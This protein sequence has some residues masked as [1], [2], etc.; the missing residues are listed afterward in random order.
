MINIVVISGF[1]GSGKSTF[2]RYLL[3]QPE[4]KG[5]QVIINEF[6]PISVDH[7]LVHFAAERTH[8][9]AGGCL[10][11]AYRQDLPQILYPLLDT[12]RAN[13]SR[14][15]AC[16]PD[17]IL[18]TTGL[19]D[20]VAIRH[21]LTADPVLRHQVRITKML[22]TIDAAHFL[23]NLSQYPEVTA[24]C[25][26]ADTFLITK[27]D[28]VSEEAIAQIIA[29]LT[30][31][32]PTASIAFLDHGVP[33]TDVTALLASTNTGVESSTAA[34]L[35]ELPVTRHTESVRSATY[36][37]PDDLDLDFFV[38]WFSLLIHR[39]GDKL[40]RVKGILAPPN[41]TSP[42]LFQALQHVIHEPEHIHLA[43]A[44]PTNTL[45]L[46]TKDILPET[47]SHSLTTLRDILDPKVPSATPLETDIVSRIAQQ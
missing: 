19:A 21:T 2:L 4:F 16:A 44:T 46:I 37:L 27:R 22:V 20:P 23:S 35:P 11:C 29:A 7:H 10:C 1:L 38:T 47:V 18:E 31:I 45:V 26:A 34:N 13:K 8:L 15:S 5:T 28:L 14:A 42:V 12:V 32:N 30:S 33:D 43:D 39:H 41:A 40:L 24:Q 6:G 17:I 36:T 3:A 25:V 9:L